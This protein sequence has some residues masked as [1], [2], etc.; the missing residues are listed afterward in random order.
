TLSTGN[1]YYTGSGGT[2]SLLNAGDVI[3]SSQTIYIYTGTASCNNE[4]SFTITLSGLPSVDSLSDVSACSSYT[5]PALST[6]NFYYTGSRGTGTLLNA[7]DV[8]TSSQTI[9]IFTG[10]VSCNNESSF[11]V[12]INNCLNSS[13]TLPNAFTPNGD[14][15][16]DFFELAGIEKSYPNFNIKIYNRVGN[17]LFNYTHDGS[18][19]N[20]PQWWDGTYNGV[21]LPQGTYYYTLSYNKNDLLPKS[22]WIYL[23]Y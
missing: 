7:G 10:T 18:I 9:H 14:G 23:N 12:T 15:K 6:G 2:G 20:Q 13:F 17:I 22:S 19:I 4:S 16:N 11:I 8:I 3:T 21:K 1:F 5:L